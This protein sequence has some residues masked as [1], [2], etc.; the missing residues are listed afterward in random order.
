VLAAAETELGKPYRWG[1]TG[2]GSFDCS[3]LVQHVFAAAGVALPRTSRQQWYAGAHPANDD[4]RPGDLLFWADGDHPA[5]IH[6]VAVY[7]GSGYM[8]AAPH[9]GAL[10]RVQPV[11]D[12]GFFGVT[13]VAAPSGR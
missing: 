11:Y 5:S 9:T 3:G 2:P 6:H 13:R 7:L 1:A 8:I 12:G 10:V 4:I